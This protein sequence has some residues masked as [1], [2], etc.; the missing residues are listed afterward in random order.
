MSRA[1]RPIHHMGYWVEDLA[2][3]IERFS[4]ELGVGPFAVHEHVTFAE[5]VMPGHDAVVFDHSAAFAAW[6]SIVIELGQVHEIDDELAG[7]MGADPG[8]VSHVS[9]LAPDLEA[10]QARLAQFGCEL[11]NTARTGP[12]SV[13]WVTGGELVAHP[14]EVH[15]DTPFIRGMQPRLSALAEDWTGAPLT[16]PIREALAP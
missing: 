3:G 4:A 10:E 1:A 13:L 14:I 6:G 2:E 9:W 5:F 15:L 12:V 16:L 7:L 8:T 11:I